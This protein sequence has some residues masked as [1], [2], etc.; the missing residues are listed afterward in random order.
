VSARDSDSIDFRGATHARVVNR[1]R[2]P[3]VLRA[4][5][6]FGQQR[7]DHLIRP[8]RT[9]RL[10]RVTVRRANDERREAH[11]RGP[12]ALR[13]SSGRSRRVVRRAL[14]DLAAPMGPRRRL[15]ALSGG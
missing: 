6:V 15:P 1:L 5:L 13:F 4:Q 14:D 8:N 9:R 7:F 3:F 11:Q 10:D 12:R 2:R